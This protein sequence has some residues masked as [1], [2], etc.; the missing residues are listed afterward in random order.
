MQM[1]T[2]STDLYSTVRAEQLSYY[3]LILVKDEQQDNT[4][5]HQ[6]SLCLFPT[7]PSAPN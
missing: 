5:T 4:V 7:Q 6:R 3:S 1:E 2:A